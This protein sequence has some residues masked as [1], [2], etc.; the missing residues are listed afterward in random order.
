MRHWADG[1]AGRVLAA[2]WADSQSLRSQG[3]C[4]L[5]LLSC[6]MS[7]AGDIPRMPMWAASRAERRRTPT[8]PNRHGP[9]QKARHYGV[10][11]S[12]GPGRTPEISFGDNNFGDKIPGGICWLIRGIW[13]GKTHGLGPNQRAGTSG[14]G[15]RDNS[16]GTL[17]TIQYT[18]CK[19][20]VTKHYSILLTSA[21]GALFFEG[22]TVQFLEA[23]RSAE[24]PWRRGEE[25]NFYKNS[26]EIYGRKTVWATLPKSLLHALTTRLARC[27]RH[28]VVCM[29][30]R[31][32][33][34]KVWIVYF[35]FWWLCALS[36]CKKWKMKSKIRLRSIRD[37][38]VK[39][40]QKA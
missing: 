17:N 8:A 14:S 15:T 35:V 29:H 4:G 20:T 9:L 23:H 7:A 18:K 26:K 13:A 32:W 1:R 31:V 28:W 19:V 22:T 40:R 30:E 34:W 12:S 38:I 39:H 6:A 2:K 3:C 21:D 33:F 11:H 25:S 5:S 36:I 27:T 16:Y 37:K 10:G 24:K